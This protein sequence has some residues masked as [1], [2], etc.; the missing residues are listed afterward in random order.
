MTSISKLVPLLVATTVLVAAPPLAASADEGEKIFTES[1]TGCHNAKTRPLDA[2]R[3]TR[4]KW[5]K[6][7]ERMEAMGTDVPGGKKR[8]EL[9]DWLV[10]THGPDSPAAPASEGRK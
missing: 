2:T 3:L 9:L 10:R 1:C 8:S 6:S 5:S 7:I 4:E